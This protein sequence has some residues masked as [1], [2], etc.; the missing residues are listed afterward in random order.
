MDVDYSPYYDELN[1]SENDGYITTTANTLIAENIFL[2]VQN[3]FHPRNVNDFL[4]GLINS[5][6]KALPGF[7]HRNNRP[8]GRLVIILNKC[9]FDGAQEDDMLQKIRTEYDRF[10]NLIKNYF[11]KEMEL[12][13]LP[14]LRWDPVNKPDFYEENFFLTY[15]HI[16]SAEQQL[17]MKMMTGLAKIT[18]LIIESSVEDFNLPCDKFEDYLS[19]LYER[20]SLSTLVISEINEKWSSGSSGIRSY[21]DLINFDFTRFGLRT[22]FHQNNQTYYSGY[23]N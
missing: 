14:S 4:N 20:N 15:D 6:D 22:E 17:S 19:D 8:F 3:R 10:W 13:V 2:V 18:K 12:I 21:T 5:V 11:H 16:R 1:L 9:I 23:S 7:T